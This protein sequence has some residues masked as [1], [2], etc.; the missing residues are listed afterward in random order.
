MDNLPWQVVGIMDEERLRQLYNYQQHHL[1]LVRDALHAG[2]SQRAALPAGGRAAHAPPSGVPN[3]PEAL[4]EAE[5]AKDYNARIDALEADAIR[6]EN[7]GMRLPGANGEP[8]MWTAAMRRL[9]AAETARRAREFT[10]ARKFVEKSRLHFFRFDASYVEEGKLA[11]DQGDYQAA[12]AAF[13]RVLDINRNFDG[14]NV[15]LVRARAA[16]DRQKRLEEEAERRGASDAVSL[17]ERE[18]AFC[19]AWRQTGGCMPHG[20]REPQRDMPCDARI[21]AGNSGFCECRTHGGLMAPQANPMT[22]QGMGV[23]CDE[24]CSAAFQG[25]MSHLQ[26]TSEADT[27]VAF[28]KQMEDSISSARAESLARQNSPIVD[29]V[30]KMLKQQYYL[31]LS[32]PCDFTAKELKV[33]FRKESLRMHPDKHGGSNDGFQIVSQA[34]DLLSD[35]ERRRAFDEGEDL[36]T[37]DDDNNER[38][39]YVVRVTKEYYPDRFGFHPFGDPFERKRQIVEQERKRRE[40]DEQRRNA[41][42]AAIAAEEEAQ[43]ERERE[44]RLDAMTTE[45]DA[46]EF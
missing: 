33:A 30:R 37:D 9:Q 16:I 34:H 40:L 29:L 24:A 44:R 1:R 27:L 21:P 31:I 8:A 12:L 2:E 19:I 18:T 26:G 11:Y 28:A 32:L 22:C 15:W 4:L 41:A 5:E 46:T 38:E 42:A 17:V 10:L 36:R 25:R 20:P 39:P 13:A 23:R 3:P 7:E 45:H 14:L 35:D 43:K 6:L